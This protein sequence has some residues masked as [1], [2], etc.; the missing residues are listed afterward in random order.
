[1]KRVFLAASL[2]ILVGL[3]PASPRAETW[4]AGSLT[5]SDELGGFKLLS[6]TGSGSFLDPIVI[7]E[8]IMDVGP[9]VLVIRRRERPR[10]GSMVAN[11]CRCAFRTSSIGTP[12]R[13]IGGHRP[14]SRCC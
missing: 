6:V 5:F 3:S 2:L 7:V 8:E 14:T 12:T 11:A 10:V 9:A 4:A 13:A 1:M